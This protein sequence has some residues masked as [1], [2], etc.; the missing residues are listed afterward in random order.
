MACILPAKTF[1]ALIAQLRTSISLSLKVQKSQQTA[2]Y[3][4]D[5]YENDSFYTDRQYHGQKRSQTSSSSANNKEQSK[6][7]FGKKACFVCSKE[8]CW[9]TRHSP[10]ERM[11]SMADFKSKTLRLTGRKYTGPEIRQFLNDFE[12][13]EPAQEIPD[14]FSHF[15]VTQDD[16]ESDDLEDFFRTGIFFTDS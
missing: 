12:G 4:A 6:T 7:K 8:G 11:K 3:T 5:G 15:H 16:E 9:S 13:L 10:E 1:Q 14:N 2:Y